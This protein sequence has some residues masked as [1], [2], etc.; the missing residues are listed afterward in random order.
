M[1]GSQQT[2]LKQTWI[3]L[4]LQRRK[5]DDWLRWRGKRKHSSE[6]RSAIDQSQ[7]NFAP[8]LR[9]PTKIEEGG[10][11]GKA[12]NIELQR[13]RRGIVRGRR[14]YTHLF[15]LIE[16]VEFALRTCVDLRCIPWML[17]QM[18]N[19]GWTHASKMNTSFEGKL[20]PV[21]GQGLAII[22]RKD[23]NPLTSLLLVLNAS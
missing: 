19:I 15:L 21:E 20:K 5:R 1:A 14:N 6:M 11:G 22:Q 3:R 17:Y 7:F 16:G 4:S 9:F 23:F 18:D 10:K 8:L 13:W 12:I 2:L